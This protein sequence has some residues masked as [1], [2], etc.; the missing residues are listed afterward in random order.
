MSSLKR[1]VVAEP[2]NK[3]STPLM[4]LRPGSKAMREQTDG[5]CEDFTSKDI[6]DLRIE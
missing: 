4:S 2:R 6:E 1:L 5:L 3:S